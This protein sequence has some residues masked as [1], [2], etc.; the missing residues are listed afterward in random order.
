M[1]YDF[2]DLYLVFFS[3]EL[4]TRYL[5]LLIGLGMI[6]SVIYLIWVICRGYV[7]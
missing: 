1:L 7:K 4:F 3:S 2:L 6:P 5:V